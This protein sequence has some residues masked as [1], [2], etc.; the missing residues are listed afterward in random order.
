MRAHARLTRL[1]QAYAA[2]RLRSLRQV[3]IREALRL[4]EAFLRDD[5]ETLGAARQAKVKALA[6]FVFVEIP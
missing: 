3:E 2:R 4:L 6:R 1:E 5:W